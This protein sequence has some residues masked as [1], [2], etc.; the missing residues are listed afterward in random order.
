M[1]PLPAIRARGS[2]TVVALDDDPA[3]GT[4][5]VRDVTVLTRWTT[6][7][8]IGVL[9]ERLPVVYVLT[10][11]RSLAPGAAADLAR[12]LGRQA[13]DA[14]ASSGRGWSVVSRSNSTLRGHFPLEVDALAEGLALPEA[15]PARTVPR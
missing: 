1:D 9:A 6:D 14:T 4:Q 8:L 11:S 13:R 12:G 7:G 15:R 10:N 2:R 3:A 5:T